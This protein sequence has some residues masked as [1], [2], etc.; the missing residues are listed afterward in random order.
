MAKSK[1]GQGLNVVEL[2]FNK[3]VKIKKEYLKLSSS[4]LIQWNEPLER[5]LYLRQEG[6]NCQCGAMLD[7]TRSYNFS[8][9]ASEATFLSP[10]TPATLFFWFQEVLIISRLMFFLIL[11]CIFNYRGH[12]KWSSVLSGQKCSESDQ[13][14]I[15]QY[16]GIHV[17]LR[18]KFRALHIHALYSEPILLASILMLITQG[19]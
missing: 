16:R 8:P 1:S 19:L 13:S 2:D 9:G 15:L 4:H 7:K 3:V 10:L 11:F 18:L 6:R 14:Y 5:T 12:F 17:V